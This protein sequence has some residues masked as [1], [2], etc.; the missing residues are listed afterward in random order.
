MHGGCPISR[1]AGFNLRALI[2]QMLIT[3]RYDLG[4]GEG[5]WDCTTCQTCTLRCPKDVHPSDLV[6]ALRSALIEDGKAPRTLG[7]A[8]TSVFRNGNPWELARANRADWAA[9]LPV[10][11]ALEEPVEVLYYAGCTPSYDPR[12]QKMARALVTILDRAGVTVGT[13][14]TQ[15]TCCG[16]EVRRAGEMGLFEMLVEEGSEMLKA[17]QAQHMITTSPHCFD[18]FTHHY[19]SPGYPIEHYTQYL[20]R[21]LADG[22]LAFTSKVDKRVT[23]H[24]PC[25]LGKQNKIFDEPRAILQS[26]PGL[27]LVEMDRSRETSLCCEGGGGRMWCEG[28]NPDVRLANERV[29]E[30]LDTGA[31]VLATACPFCLTMLEDAAKTQNLVDKIEVKDVAELVAEAL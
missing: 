26:I 22:R 15:E 13:L 9:D 6:I 28:V 8:L 30:A 10:K 12:A 31:Q 23:Y 4:S 29:V 21:L 24:D 25:Y 18:V 11:N 1:K 7:T 5:L 20:A 14:G 27:E 16:S 17:A 2:Y 19:Q 3:D